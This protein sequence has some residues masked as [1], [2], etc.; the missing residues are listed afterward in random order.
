MPSGLAILDRPLGLLLD[1]GVGRFADLAGR[2]IP[3]VSLFS[4]LVAALQ[5]TRD[6]LAAARPAPNVV[7][8]KPE[9]TPTPTPLRKVA[10]GSG[11]GT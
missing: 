8:S 10:G 6:R 7:P 3:G 9:P 1:D 5:K 11:S 2:A 4:P